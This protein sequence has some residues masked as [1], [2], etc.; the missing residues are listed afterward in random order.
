MDNEALTACVTVFQR[1]RIGRHLTGRAVASRG[2]MGEGLMDGARPGGRQL[3]AS[4][5]LQS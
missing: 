4:G 1:S 3:V 2:L 5:E